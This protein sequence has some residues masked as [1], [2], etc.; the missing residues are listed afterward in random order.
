MTSP[1]LLAGRRIV[2]TRAVDQVG[3]LSALL[4]DAGAVVIEVPTIAIVEPLDGGAGLNVAVAAAAEPATAGGYDWIVVT[5]GNGASRLVTA[6]R[7]AGLS[8]EDVSARIAVVGPGTADVLGAYGWSVELVPERFVGEGLVEAF[9]EGPGRVLVAQAE[10]AR[11]IVVDGLRAK[12]WTVDAVIAYRTIPAV[13]DASLIAHA[14]SADAITFT[15]SST[16]A[17]YVQAA[18]AANVPDVVVCIG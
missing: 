17:N 11:P 18:G 10:A 1:G 4:A 13:L 7:S 6:A 12:G 14:A 15:S 16:V 8:R 9:D 5:S 2:V 3:T